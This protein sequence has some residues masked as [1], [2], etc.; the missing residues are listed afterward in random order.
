MHPCTQ[1]GK[2]LRRNSRDKKS[3]RLW[4]HNVYH[5]WGPYKVMRN[6]NDNN[7]NNNNY[8]YNLNRVAGKYV[9]VSQLLNYY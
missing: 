7:N 2:W 5:I 3:I 9:A 6:N 1:N 8:V 4:N